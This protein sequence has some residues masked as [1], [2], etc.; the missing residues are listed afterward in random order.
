M[1][2]GCGNYS[3]AMRAKDTNWLTVEHDILHG[4]DYTARGLGNEFG[5]AM[6]QQLKRIKSRPRHTHMGTVCTSFS[7]ANT[8]DP[9][10]S[11]DFPEGLPHNPP[12]KRAKATLG[13]FFT[14]E[15]DDFSVLPSDVLVGLS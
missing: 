7:R 8:K 6:L 9:V 4:L 5:T 11:N 2:S 15:P 10:R 14:I 3:K 13:F 1:F 12:G